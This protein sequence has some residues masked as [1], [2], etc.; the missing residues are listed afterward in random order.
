[1]I[2]VA[3][4]QN[5]KVLRTHLFFLPTHSQRETETKKRPNK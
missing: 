4:A 1:M 2:L 5:K 3:T